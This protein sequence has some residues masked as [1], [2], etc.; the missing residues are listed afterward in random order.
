MSD[1]G[2]KGA[3]NSQTHRCYGLRDVMPRCD[4]RYRASAGPFDGG[5]R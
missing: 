2:Y 3:V 5:K 4:L 1:N